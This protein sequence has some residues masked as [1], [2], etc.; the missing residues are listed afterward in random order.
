MLSLGAPWESV[1]GQVDGGTQQPPRAPA[2]HPIPQ[3]ERSAIARA[4]HFLES[5]AAQ[6]ADPYSSTLTT[7][8]LTLLHSPA[9]PAALRKLRSL[10]IT[11]GR[12][13]PLPPLRPLWGQPTVHPVDASRTHAGTKEAPLLTLVCYWSHLHGGS[14]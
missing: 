2:P 6:A 9:A 4:R 14:I 7:Y 12:G 3:E 1:G 8:A 10:A 5:S 11:Q 13:P